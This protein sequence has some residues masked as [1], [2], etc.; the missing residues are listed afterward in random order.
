[1]RPPL[2]VAALCVVAGTA[3]SGAQDA[4]RESRKV[5]P[6]VGGATRLDQV[7]A[8]VD[9]WQVEVDASGMLGADGKQ[10]GDF[11]LA[12]VET[13]ISYNTT[14]R[15]DLR[16]RLGFNA[17]QSFYDFDDVTTIVPGTDDP[18]DRLQAY[19]L[20]GALFWRA[21][22][23]WS[24]FGGLEVR[25]AFESGADFGETLELRATAGAE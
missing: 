10:R 17:Q 22:E 8:P 7:A 23:R 5:E 16:L 3:P 15:D 2:V 24:Y 25:S 12:R 21:N 11:D 18:W 20:G 14:L 6:P 13:G 4:A 19:R 1:M 9:F